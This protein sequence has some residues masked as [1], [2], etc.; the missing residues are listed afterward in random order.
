M[1]ASLLI[2]EFL[3]LV[4][5]ILVDAWKG[6]RAGIIAAIVC[7]VIMVTYNYLLFGEFDKFVLGEAVMI[8]AMGLVSLK[9]NN[10]RYFKFQ[11]TVLALIFSGVFAWFQIFDQPLMLHFLPH[12]EK[13][14]STES[15][16][17]QA[18]ETPELGSEPRAE[19]SVLTVLHSESFKHVLGRISGQ[20]IWLFLA[21]G[22]IMAYAA[23]RWSTRSWFA[24]RLGIYP[25]LL[26]IVVINQLFQ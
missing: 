21:H 3:P 16:A 22:L 25:G 17:L 4:V 14:I 26:M 23:L 2:V 1:N 19:E 9:M 6:F 7:T 20:L 15:V 5:Y 8:V 24:W 10:D 12:M 11:P 13:L 18:R